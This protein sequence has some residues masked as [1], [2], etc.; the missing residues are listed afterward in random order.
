MACSHISGCELFVQ[1]ALNPALELWKRAYCNG[2]YAT[3]VRYK[4]AVMGQQVPLSLLPNG[5]KIQTN[6]SQDEL[7][8]TA[9]F[10]CIEKNRLRMASSL[11]KAVGVDI[12]ACN[13]EGTTALM[14][15]VEIGSIEMIKLLLSFNPDTTMTNI[16]GQTAYNLALE[17]NEPAR[18]KL[19][20][21]Y[22]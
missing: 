17:K 18:I 5:K 7:A 12:N 1:F 15:A 4:T 22:N 16:H 2:D 8:I 6:R 13:V 3:C 10:N 21:R 19:L 14:A 11:V 9:L 20:Q